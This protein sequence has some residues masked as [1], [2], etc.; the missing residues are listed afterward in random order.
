MPLTPENHKPKARQDIP[1]WAVIVHNE[2]WLQAQQQKPAW[3]TKGEMVLSLILLAGLFG[4]IFWFTY[5]IIATSA[6]CYN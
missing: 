4:S 6:T 5:W 3:Q 2:D 1:R